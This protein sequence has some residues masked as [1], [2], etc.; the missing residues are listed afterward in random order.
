MFTIRIEGLNRSRSQHRHPLGLTDRHSGL[1]TIGRTIAH[2]IYQNLYQKYL[3]LMKFL[4]HVQI[5]MP[6][7]HPGG[8]GL[9]SGHYK[10]IGCAIN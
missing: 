3:V 8:I 2:V 9:V 1:S 7:S 4:R 5:L 6:K 10:K